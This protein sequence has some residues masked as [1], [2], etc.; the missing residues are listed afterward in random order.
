MTRRWQLVS[1][2]VVLACA[3]MVVACQTAPSVHQQDKKPGATASLPQGQGKP[4][5]QPSTESTVQPTPF[6][7]LT[8]A[9]WEALPGISDENWLVSWPVW[10]KSCQGLKLKPDWRE[11]CA[12]ALTVNASDAQAIQAYWQ[13]YFSVYAT[14][15]NDATQ[16][17]L[18]TGYYQPIL[19]GAAASSQRYNVPLYQLPSDL[20][21]VNLSGLFPELK[22]KRVRGRV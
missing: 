6:A 12:L 15:Q 10:L 13:Q 9:T 11:V 17:G 19:K 1:R 5:V 22:Y 14:R 18:M 7:L 8:P 3:V 16:Q 2:C 21:T 4:P 20:I